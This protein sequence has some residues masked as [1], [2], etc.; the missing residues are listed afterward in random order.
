MGGKR[1][2]ENNLYNICQYSCM[3][4]SENKLDKGLGDVDIEDRDAHRV[5][6]V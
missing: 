2:G 3:E 5:I 4:F 6:A 1:E